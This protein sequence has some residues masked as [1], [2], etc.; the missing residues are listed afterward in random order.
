MLRYLPFIASL[1]LCALS[2][3]GLV[4]LPPTAI[5]IVGTIVFGFFSLVG[6]IDLFSKH[7]LRRLYPLICH[8]RYISETLGPAIQQYFIAT[9]T[10]GRPYSEQQR[11]L[12][13]ERAK[14]IEDTVPFG[15]QMDI[16]E[17]GYISAK[18][19]LKPI[20][21]TTVLDR[22]SFGDDLCKQPYSASR[23]NISAMSFGAINSRAIRALNRGAKMSGMAHNTGEGGL[24]SHHLKEGG[25]I[26]W[27]IGTAYFGTRDHEGNFCPKTFAEKANHPA[28]KMIEIKLS[29]GAKPAHGGV[30]PAAKITDEIAYIRGIKKGQ[31]CISPPTHSAF[32]TPIELLEFVTNLRELSGGKPVGFKLCLGKKTEFM[33]ICKAMLKTG[34]RPDFITIDG[35]EGGTGAAPVEFTNRL[36]TPANSALAFIYNCLVG[37]NLNRKI[38]LISSAK[39]TSGFDVVCRMALGANTCN[40]ARPMMFALGCIQSLTCNTNNCPTGIATSK[41]SRKFAINIQNRA[42]RVANF[43]N[44]TIKSFTEIMA[45]MGAQTPIDLNPRMIHFSYGEGISKTCYDLFNYIEPGHLLSDDIHLAYK[46]LWEEASAESF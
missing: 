21:T 19:S 6:T 36:G 43:H 41:K 2:I 38:R 18:H 39:V 37:I 5:T 4:A 44:N 9:T 13:Y 7:N 32:S 14:N 16:T 1:L 23:I 15:T 3:T 22:V 20:K 45:A 42:T 34:M 11:T 35:A 46:H 31:D 17:Y 30:L 24:S 26:I 25:D 12:I 40:M 8:I 29:Q 33:G 27:Q 28:V 10:S